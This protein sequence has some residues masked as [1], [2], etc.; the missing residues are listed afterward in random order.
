MLALFAASLCL[1]ISPGGLS[2]DYKAK[3]RS[4][5]FNLK[6]P[7]NPEL[8]ARVLRGEIAPQVS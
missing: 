4:L 8:R 5:I 1:C 3:F 6:D 7:N 2:N